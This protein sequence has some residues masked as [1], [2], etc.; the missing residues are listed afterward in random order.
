MIWAD[1]EA[2][3]LYQPSDGITLGPR[4]LEGEDGVR[5]QPPEVPTEGSDADNEG[6][7]LDNEDCDLGPEAYH[8]MDT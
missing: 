3:P 7:W 1:E 8:N 6:Y 4:A 2:P 5:N